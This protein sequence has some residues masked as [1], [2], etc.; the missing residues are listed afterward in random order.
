MIALMFEIYGAV[1]LFSLIAF[2]VLAALA[3]FRPDLDEEEF[4]FIEPEKLTQLV[5]AEQSANAF[6]LEPAIMEGSFW[7]PPP[8]PV[9]RSRRLTQRRPQ[10]IHMHK[11]RTI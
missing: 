1:C 7:S 4:D 3:K 10:L 2:L 11:P 9:K 8:R 6:S 5:N